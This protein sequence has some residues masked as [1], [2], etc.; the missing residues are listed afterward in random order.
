MDGGGG[1]GGRD[2]VGLGGE[3]CR[4]RKTCDGVLGRVGG[5]PSGVGV[6][7]GQ[8]GGECGKG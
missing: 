2:G 3:E 1:G 4:L 8:G 7:R 6:K 5:G